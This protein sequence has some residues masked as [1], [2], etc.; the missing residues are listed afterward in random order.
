[1]LVKLVEVSIFIVNN[2]K[3][4]VKLLFT[5]K[6]SSVFTYIAAPAPNEIDD[7]AVKEK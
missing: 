2:I 5:M 7:P 3:I 1:M 4:N 6:T